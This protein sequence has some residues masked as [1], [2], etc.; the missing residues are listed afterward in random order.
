MCNISTVVSYH[1]NGKVKH[2]S[3]RSEIPFAAANRRA[4]GAT[5]CDMSKTSPSSKRR[6]KLFKKTM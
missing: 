6:R 5:C 4:E 2:A 1:F 3:G